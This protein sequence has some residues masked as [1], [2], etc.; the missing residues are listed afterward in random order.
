MIISHSPVLLCTRILHLFHHTTN[1][2]AFDSKA[3][4]NLYTLLLLSH[5]L[6]QLLSSEIHRCGQHLEEDTTTS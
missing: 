5:E 3:A 4:H 6:L 2:S 1:Q